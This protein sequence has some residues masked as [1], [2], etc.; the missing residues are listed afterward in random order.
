MPNLNLLLI[1]VLMGTFP[2][3]QSPVIP[4]S[5]KM[6]PAIF[7]FLI[8]AFLDWTDG[9]II[10]FLFTAVV[11]NWVYQRD[12]PNWVVNNMMQKMIKAKDMMMQKMIKAKAKI[13]DA[14]EDIV[15]DK[16]E[17]LD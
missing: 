3:L 13:A 5:K 9:S 2:T 4:L 16:V 7:S 1:G 10:M 12:I 17:N 11:T 6:V 15:Q 8:M 14:I